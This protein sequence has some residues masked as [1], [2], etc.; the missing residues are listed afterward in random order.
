M[1]FLASAELKR[2]SPPGLLAFEVRDS[3]KGLTNKHTENLIILQD[4]SGPLPK[5]SH[6]QEHILAGWLA[7]RPGWL[8][9]P[10]G[11]LVGTVGWLAGW[12]LSLTSWP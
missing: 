4:L 6:H 11:S 2:T 7:L 1:L 12:I 5:K 8:A 9:G 10:E 3:K